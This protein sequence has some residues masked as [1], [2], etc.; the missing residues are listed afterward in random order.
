MT[1][2]QGTRFGPYEVIALIGKGGM[3]EV[4]RDRDSRLWRH[5]AIKIL[6]REFTSDPDR[7]VPVAPGRWPALRARGPRPPRYQPP[8]YSP[9]PRRQRRRGHVCSGDGT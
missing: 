2:P 1:L 4:Y 9:H 7:E 8:S 5:V 3:G 6:S